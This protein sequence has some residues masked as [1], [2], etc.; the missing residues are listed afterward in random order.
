[1]ATEAVVVAVGAVRALGFFF[2]GTHG[3]QTAFARATSSGDQV[4]PV[5]DRV[6]P[7][8]DAPLGDLAV[9]A[10]EPHRLVP[11]PCAAPSTLHQPKQSVQGLAEADLVTI[12]LKSPSPFIHQGSGSSRPEWRRSHACVLLSQSDLRLHV[13]SAGWPRK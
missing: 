10:V 9:D 8:A 12:F 2:S 13:R 3:L 5:D 6:A 1:M 7:S 11:A 4:I